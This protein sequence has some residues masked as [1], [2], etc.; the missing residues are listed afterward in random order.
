MRE[1]GG[2]IQARSVTVGVPSASSRETRASPTA[3]SWIA[4][5]MSRPGLGRIVSA[6]A[7]TAF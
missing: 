5:S 1:P 6:V 7:R 3:S 4:A 2:R